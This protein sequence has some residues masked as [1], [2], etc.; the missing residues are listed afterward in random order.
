[1]NILP[2]TWLDLVRREYLARFIREGGAAVKFVVPSA[3]MEPQDWL[4]PLRTSAEAEGFLFIGV[5]AAETKLHMIEQLFFAVARAVPWDTLARS[6]VSRLI[7]EHGYSVPAAP[8]AL[9]WQNLATLNEREETLLRRDLA[10]WLEAA[11]YKNYAMSQDFRRA[12]IQLCLCQLDGGDAPAFLHVAIKEWLCGELRLISALKEALIVQK[13]ARHNARHLF[14]SLTHWLHVVG[15]EGLVL[16]LDI[17]RYLVAGRAGDHGGAGHFYTPAAVLDA[18]E[19]LRQFI[20][21]CDELTHG[22]IV[23]VAPSAFLSD[24]QR[25]LNRYDALKLRIWDEVRD[26]GRANPFAPLVRLS[27]AA[28]PAPLA[29]RW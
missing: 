4:G 27:P 26:K 7:T 17:G 1:M 11:I 29:H 15:L 13:V 9:T 18:Y 10:V 6:Y 25:G 28:V 23:V 8:A 14:F 21:G 2:A 19:V 3:D 16:T 24:D 5:D 12:M 22:L 20:D